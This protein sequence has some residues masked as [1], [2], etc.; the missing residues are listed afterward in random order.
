MN[1]VQQIETAES[2]I[3]EYKY[4]PPKKYRFKE[5]ALISPITVSNWR[6]QKF[7]DQIAIVSD[8][9]IFIAGL[10]EGFVLNMDGEIFFRSFCIQNK[11]FVKAIMDVSEEDA[12]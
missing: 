1:Q 10:D 12:D 8:D 5:N 2:S 9:V 11:I 7:D 6:L 3:Y 4:T